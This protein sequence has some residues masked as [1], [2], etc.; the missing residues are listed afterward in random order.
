MP[1]IPAH[2]DVVRLK[3]IV[4]SLQSGVWGNDPKEDKNDIYCI[5]VA[6]F[7]RW[8]YGI[9]EEKLTIRNIEE[10]EQEGRLLRL[11]DLIIEKSGGGDISPVG[12]VVFY[13]LDKKAVS[14]NFIAR[15]NIGTDINREYL[16]FIFRTLYN[17]RLNIPSIKATTGIQNLDLYSYFQHKIPIPPL[18]EQADLV[19]Y[20]KAKTEKINRFIQKKQRVIELLKEQRQ[21]IISKSFFTWKGTNR[22]KKSNNIDWARSAIK[23]LVK[24]K[25]TDG[26]HESPVFSEEGIP[27]VSAEAS[28]DGKI[29]L[30]KKRCNISVEL[31]KEYCLKAKPQ[32]CD[33]LMVKSGSTTGKI[34]IVDFDDEFSIW[35]PLALIRPNELVSNEYFFYFLCS[36]HFQE[37]VQ[38][39]WSFGTQPNIGMGKIE[40]LKIFYPESIP[41]QHQIVSRIKA[42]TAVIDIA[43]T[44]AEKEIALVKEYKETMI[45]EAVTGKIVYLQKN[46]QTMQTLD[47]SNRS[48]YDINQ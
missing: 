33:L 42:E 28:C 22:Q 32:K 16:Y 4:P 24:I 9:S 3:S 47:T 38:K 7:D 48:I 6:D 23:R 11:K 37:Q 25:I 46:N 41:E 19:N 17:G 36:E 15:L 2:W 20:I 39:N 26:P 10:K 44:K 45:L 18:S 12:R 5:R 34:A 43:I 31:H 30:T 13:N 35:S 40:Q 21:C 1:Q 29:D 14:S 27:F 8:N